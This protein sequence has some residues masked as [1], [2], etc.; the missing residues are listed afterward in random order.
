MLMA[1]QVSDEMCACIITWHEEKHLSPKEIADLAGCCVHTVYYIL[2]Y[3]HEFNT[4]WDPFTHGAHGH[5]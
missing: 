2:S 4:S 3:H 1:P 5:P